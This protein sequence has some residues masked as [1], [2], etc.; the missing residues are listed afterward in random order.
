[1]QTQ[2]NT[3]KLKQN[4]HHN[5]KS[6]TTKTLTQKMVIANTKNTKSKKKVIANINQK[7]QEQK[8]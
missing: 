2:K 6:K 5:H 1:M 3:K 8:H 7:T 4:S